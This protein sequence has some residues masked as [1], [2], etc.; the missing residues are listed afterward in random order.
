LTNDHTDKLVT[1]GIVGPNYNKLKMDGVK[2]N[3]STKLNFRI[4]IGFLQESPEGEAMVTI[5]STPL[6]PRLTFL[7]EFFPLSLKT[8]IDLTIQ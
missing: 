4:N 2:C 3:L 8:L 5:L 6:S 1:K 7:C